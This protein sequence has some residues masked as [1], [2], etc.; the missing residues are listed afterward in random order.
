MT[1]ATVHSLQ[2]R[3]ASPTQTPVIRRTGP[4]QTY[5]EPK[6]KN[7]F[8]TV[9]AAIFLLSVIAFGVNRLR[10]EFQAARVRNN[11]TPIETSKTAATPA[12]SAS[13][14]VTQDATA[15]ASNAAVAQTTADADSNKTLPA[16]TVAAAEPTSVEPIPAPVTAPVAAPKKSEPALSATAAEY[17]GRIE[18][19]I[20]EQGLASRVKVQGSGNTLALV[21]KLRP[22]EHATLLRFMRNAPAAVHVVDDTQYDDTVL[23]GS[24]KGQDGSHPVPA[25]GKSAIHVITD[26]IG[27]VATLYG[28]AGREIANCTTPC[29]FDDLEARRYSLQVQKDGYQSVQ[30][31]FELKKGDSLDQKLHLESLAKGLLVTSHPAGADI[32]INGA[33]QSGQTPANLPLGPGQYDLVLRLAGY[34]AYSGHVQ[35]K[36]NIQTSLNADLKERSQTHVAW[37][38]VTTVPAGAEIFIDGASTGSFSPARVQMSSGT[39]VIVVR[40]NGYQAVRRV[41]ATEGSTVTVSETLKAR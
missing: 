35:V 37:A 1:V 27:A 29:S 16:K 17:K 13:Q 11:L 3:V 30:S 26:V 4:I 32:F 21:G 15:P 40:L 25:K 23:A 9:L 10:P 33:K 22:N 19:A 2:Q 18:E 39:H 41:Q 14:P 31:A 28:P 36:D 12:P 20:A 38:Q 34:E 8:L 6:K 7:T 5:E 24:E